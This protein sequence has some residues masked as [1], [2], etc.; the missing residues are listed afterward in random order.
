MTG[1]FHASAFSHISMAAFSTRQSYEIGQ[2]HFNS[3]DGEYKDWFFVVEKRRL[4]LRSFKP[5]SIMH[6]C[7]EQTNYHRVLYRV[8]KLNILANSQTLATGLCKSVINSL[9]LNPNSH[10]LT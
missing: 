1:M 4:T 9:M 7:F 8:V 5:H 3:R 2:K 6:P 10:V